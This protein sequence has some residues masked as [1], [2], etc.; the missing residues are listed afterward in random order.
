MTFRPG[1]I[2][3]G[4]VHRRYHAFLPV[5]TVESILNVD[6]AELFAAGKSVVLMDADNTL[7]PWG[8]HDIPAET[9]EWLGR[10]RAAGLQ[11]CLVSNTRN[12]VRLKKLS[13]SLGIPF[14]V[15]KFK[16]SREM[17]DHA[18]ELFSAKPSQAVMIGDQIFTDMWGANR[19]GID[20]ILVRQMHHNEFLGTKLVSRL[21]EKLIWRKI[22]L[23]LDGELDDLP[24]VEPT[25]FF[26][27]RI[28]RQFTKFVIVGLT[29]FAIDYNVRMTLMFAIPSGDELLSQSA[30]RA[31]LNAVPSLSAISA[32][33]QGVFF[34]VAATSGALLAIVNSFVWNRLWTFKIKGKENAGQQ[35]GKFFAVSIVGLMLNVLFSTL[36]NRVIPGDAK[37]AARIATVLAA[38]IVAIWN[39]AGQRLYAFRVKPMPTE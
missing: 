37:S 26:R 21:G 9:L 22:A 27:R 25:G 38:G 7:L 10:A 18:L 36:F 23:A 13:E 32:D 30:G 16:P 20:G 34:P 8:S 6:P 12:R 2:T 28:V 29:S 39:F 4:G 19:A 24:I 11:L 17:Y 35:F 15:G 14:A 3:K 33:P 1:K 5:Q 31:M